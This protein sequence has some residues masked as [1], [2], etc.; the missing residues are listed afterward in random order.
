MIAT[1]AGLLNPV[2]VSADILKALSDRR[3]RRWTVNWTAW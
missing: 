1:A 3:S 2:S